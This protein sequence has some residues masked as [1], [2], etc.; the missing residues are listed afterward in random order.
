[1]HAYMHNKYNCS[2]I[3]RFGFS[4]RIIATILYYTKAKNEKSEMKFF[5]IFR[6]NIGHCLER[7]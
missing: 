1:M 3:D 5:F 2:I 4:I 7:K 6:E